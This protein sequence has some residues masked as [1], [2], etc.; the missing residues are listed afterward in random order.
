MMLF[1]KTH[2][3]LVAVLVSLAWFLAGYQDRT[4]GGTGSFWFAIAVIVLATFSVGALMS[5]MWISAA[6]ALTALAGE[7]WILRK[8]SAAKNGKGHQC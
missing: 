7:I 8:W 4:R 2:L 3:G 6:F 5:Q 1:V